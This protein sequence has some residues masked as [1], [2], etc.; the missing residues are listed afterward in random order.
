MRKSAP[1]HSKQNK[2]RINAIYGALDGLS[3]SYS[4][5]RFYFD[6]LCT[7]KNLSSPDLI[8]HWLMTPTGLTTAITES[9]FVIN[10]TY[11]A[12]I[13]NANDHN[14]IRRFIAQK[15][16]YLRDA[17]KS[18]K[19]ANRSI[20]G[21]FQVID[22]LFNKTILPYALPIGTFFGFL[23]IINRCIIRYT[24]GQRAEMLTA[25][26][27]LLKF[28][29]SSTVVTLKQEQEYLDK[30]RHEGIKMGWI[31]LV[32]AFYSGLIDGLYLHMGII[33]IATLSP[34]L[35]IMCFCLSG[36]FS[37]LCI[38]TRLYEIY[39]EQYNL[40]ITEE[41]I[42][43]TLCS[44]KLQLEIIQLQEQLQTPCNNVETQIIQSKFFQ[45]IETTYNTLEQSLSRLQLDVSLS[46]GT[47]FLAGLRGGLAAYGAI[48]S[49]MFAISTITTLLFIPFPPMLLI[50]TIMIGLACLLS[51]STFSVIHHYLEVS[52]QEKKPKQ[53]KKTIGEFLAQLQQQL[54]N[55]SP[56]PHEICKS[57]QEICHIISDRI[58]LFPSRQ[59]LYQEGFEI[60]RSFF[61]GLGKSQKAVDFT[62]YTLQEADDKGH[63]H[64]TPIMFMLMGL[65]SFLY[66]F[67]FGIR[68]TH[69]Y[70]RAVRLKYDI[71]KNT[72]IIPQSTTESADKSSAFSTPISDA[73]AQDEITGSINQASKQFAVV[74][75]EPLTPHRQ[76]FECEFN[77][78][79]DN[80]KTYCQSSQSPPRLTT[81]LSV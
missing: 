44:K 8:H 30:R 22:K 55:S 15:F 10:L 34:S 75:E 37:L 18:V 23:A 39:N 17:F 29:E 41:K 68:A 62:L 42:K 58:Q 32:A 73:L 74:P 14:K 50:A 5:I 43:L 24:R 2:A 25:N 7:N 16:P 77:F 46:Y 53:S 13:S 4:I 1:K 3:T 31:S 59:P 66:A 64:D 49:L 81:T 21:T 6:L 72:T 52:H 80:Q 57:E 19:N 11:I 61:S 38:A 65:C 36:V 28:I 12:N 76:A 71:L 79:Y 69:S 67:V 27:A 60:L 33:T 40:L 48:E 51:F 54:Y 26:I 9:V 47:A 70:E 63:Y 35:F 20:R 45:E 56:I 78:F